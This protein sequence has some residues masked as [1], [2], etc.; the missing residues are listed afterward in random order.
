MRKPISVFPEIHIESFATVSQVE[1]TSE[2]YQG[3]SE[4]ISWVTSWEAY[5]RNERFHSDSFF[6]Y[7][8][9]AYSVPL[10]TQNTFSL[11]ISPKT[12]RSMLPKTRLRNVLTLFQS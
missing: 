6:K 7:L 10:S 5:L 4:A 1:A 9:F 11:K 3:V 12:Q 8:Y 2:N